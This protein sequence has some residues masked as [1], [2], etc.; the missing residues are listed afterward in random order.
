M[1][2]GIAD[3]RNHS[4]LPHAGLNVGFFSL[5]IIWSSVFLT[6]QVWW[7][8]CLLAFVANF[9]DKSVLLSASVFMLN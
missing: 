3:L 5:V 9:P 7:I 8:L 6:N 1:R 4:V 2:Y